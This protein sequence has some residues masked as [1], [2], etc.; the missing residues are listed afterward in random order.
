M[1]KQNV[2]QLHAYD[3]YQN[4]TEPQ[5]TEYHTKSTH[6]YNAGT[7]SQAWLKHAAHRL[8]QHTLQVMWRWH[9]QMKAIFFGMHYW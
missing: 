4:V 7:V 8:V 6:M 3:C 1:H 2:D 9:G 5:T